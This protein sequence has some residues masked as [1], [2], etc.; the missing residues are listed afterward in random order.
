[1]KQQT[2]ISKSRANL[3]TTLLASLLT[4]ILFI[5]VAQAHPLAPGLLALTETSENTFRGIWKLPNKTIE[6]GKLNPVFPPQC[7]VASY[8]TP[9]SVGTGRSQAFTLEC[10]NSILGGIIGVEGISPSGS[11]VLTRINFMDGSVVHQMLNSQNPKVEIPEEQ[12]TLDI[13]SRYLVL[14]VEHLIFGIDHVLFVITLALLVGWCTQLIW[15]ITLF[16]V[17]HSVTLSLTALGMIQFPSLIVE[18][19]IAFSIAWAAAEI[20]SKETEGILARRPWLMSGGFGLLHGMGFA[21][22]LAAIGLPQQALVTSLAA[23][24][25][26][27]EIG[28]LM[29][30]LLFFVLGAA[31]QKLINQMPTL[32][33]SGICYAIGITG[34]LWFWQ[35]LLGI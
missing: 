14:G 5:P 6:R 23:F 15:T 2:A 12:T 25:I 26:G 29:I 4:V 20:I 34:A 33:K 32:L 16:T 35:R 27:I 17:G 21:G 13:F 3:I 24:N 30:I 28:Q 31:L 1:M 18:A 19:M 10:Q 11:G 9:M 8:E 22:A 7:A